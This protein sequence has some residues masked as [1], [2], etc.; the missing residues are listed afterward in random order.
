MRKDLSLTL[1]VG[2]KG[3]IERF[4]RRSIYTRADADKLMSAI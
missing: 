4:L 1:V 2:S 3:E